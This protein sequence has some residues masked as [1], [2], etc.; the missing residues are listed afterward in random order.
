MDAAFTKAL[1]IAES[2]DDS[3]T[4]CALCGVCISITTGTVDTALRCHLRKGSTISPR[5]DGPERSA[6]RRAHD[7]RRASIFLATRSV[8]GAISSKCSPDTRLP[9]LGSLRSP[10]GCHSLPDRRAVSSARLPARVLWLQG[11]ADQAV[12]TAEECLGDAQAIDHAS[13][14]C[15]ALA[16]AACPIALWMGNLAAAAHHTGLLRR[17]FEKAWPVA[18]GSLMVPGFEE[19][20]RSRVAIVEHRIRGRCD[21]SLDEIDR[22]RFNS[23]ISDRV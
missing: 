13:S 21:A 19:L 12:R 20:S 7:R 6:V 2:L 4:S 5:A 14:L 10:S 3:S 22:V 17:S 18:L 9:I 16:L 23:S 1:D 8:H 15:Y 11:F